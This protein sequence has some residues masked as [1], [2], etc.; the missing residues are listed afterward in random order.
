[1]ESNIKRRLD[2]ALQ[3]DSARDSKLRN[4]ILV[5]KRNQE[6][7]KHGILPVVKRVAQHQWHGRVMVLDHTVGA[8]E[9]MSRKNDHA[10][11]QDDDDNATEKEIGQTTT[12]T[13]TTTPTHWQSDAQ[14]CL[15]RILEQ[16]RGPN[17]VTFG[18]ATTMLYQHIRDSRISLP[19]TFTSCSDYN[20]LRPGALSGRQTITA[21]FVQSLVSTI[22]YTAELTSKECFQPE[23][24]YGD[25]FYAVN[26]LVAWHTDFEFV[27]DA[28]PET[29]IGALADSLHAY[30]EVHFRSKRDSADNAVVFKPSVDLFQGAMPAQ[31]DIG[32]GIDTVLERLKLY[33]SNDTYMYAPRSY[34]D[35]DT[36]TIRYPPNMFANTWPVSTVLVGT[37]RVEFYDVG[38]V[39]LNMHIFSHIQRYTVWGMAVLAILYAVTGC[40]KNKFNEKITPYLLKLTKKDFQTLTTSQL[41]PGLYAMLILARP[42]S[43]ISVSAGMLGRVP[44]GL[45]PFILYY[46]ANLEYTKA[47]TAAAQV[48]GIKKPV[49]HDKL[50]QLDT[51]VKAA[52]DMLQQF[53]EHVVNTAFAKS[54]NG[55]SLANQI[56][57]SSYG[58]VYK[59]MGDA[60]K[61]E[62]VKRGF[63]YTQMPRQVDPNLFQT[64]ALR[65]IAAA[66]NQMRQQIF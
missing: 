44:P 49:S 57:Y 27:R 34:M 41:F 43:D 45:R 22:S 38:V 56:V 4:Y 11:R 37:L 16:E 6:H 50:R 66:T 62:Y 40:D 13:T 46:D 14:S 54:H 15:A 30:T 48:T 3:R 19:R 17:K 61:P 1:M 12:T 7:V 29:L 53:L 2:A 65:T 35:P 42:A 9:P 18:T 64:G 24:Q 23:E 10:A 31:F 28:S 52:R 58:D 25:L 51:S 20:L 59:N 47:A 36:N 39:F 21:H 8:N 60:V 26:A 55:E 32:A 33:A 5:L 63:T